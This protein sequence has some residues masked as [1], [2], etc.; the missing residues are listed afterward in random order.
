M[1]ILVINS[2]ENI[3]AG[4][5]VADCLSA[6]DIIVRIIHRSELVSGF[7]TGGFDRVYLS[8]SE[9]SVFEEADWISAQLDFIR[10]CIDRSTPIMGICFG[11]QMIVRALY[12]KDA[13]KRREVPEV[14]W[15]D[16]RFG[17]HW[18]FTGFSSP[19]PA[20]NFHFDE[21][22]DGRIDDFSIIAGSDACPVHAIVHKEVPVVGVQFHPE[23]KPADGIKEIWDRATLLTQY[24]LD[25]GNILSGT[26][27]ARKTYLPRV[28][29]NF[30]R[31]SF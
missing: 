3:D 5:W 24:G 17:D 14:G 11:H 21:V 8:G 7:K 9:R 27:E 15:P 19:L 13:L 16:I 31:H 23:I 20:F 26:P 4:R 18:L 30:A 22:V 1:E 6:N 29:E 2:G 25:G 28:I 12:G 10:G